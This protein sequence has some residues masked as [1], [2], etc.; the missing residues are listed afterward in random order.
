MEEINYRKYMDI[1]TFSEFEI[2]HSERERERERERE[3]KNSSRETT[4]VDL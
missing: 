3:K 1:L 2:T 4:F